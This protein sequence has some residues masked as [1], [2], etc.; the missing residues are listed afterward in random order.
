MVSLSAIGLGYSLSVD[1]HS[2]T[3]V[4]FGLY[5]FLNCYLLTVSY[6]S[7]TQNDIASHWKTLI[8]LSIL[9]T[10]AL[11]T[12]VIGVVLPNEDD[13]NVFAAVALQGLWYT[14][15]ALHAIGMFIAINIPGGPPLHCDPVVLYNAK[16]VESI[17]NQD[18]ANVA[19]ITSK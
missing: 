14:S 9:S 2:L 12:F 3:N 11:I 18:P 8:R 1:I 17:T 19:G 15:L 5:T 10:L 7:I 6:F 16:T 13:S 4:T